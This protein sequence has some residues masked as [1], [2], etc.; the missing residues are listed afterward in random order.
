MDIYRHDTATSE[1]EFTNGDPAL[2]IP[3]TVL[4]AE[5]CNMIQREL[6]ALVTASGQELDG[7]NFAQVL[8][9]VQSMGFS[10]GDV[11]YTYQPQIPFGWLELNGGTIGRSG[12]G[13]SSLDNDRARPL[14][15]LLW[16]TYSNDVIPVT[17]G[18]GASAVADWDAGKPLKLFDDRNLFHRVASGLIP[19]GTW[20]DFAQQNVTG[21][22]GYIRDGREYADGVFEVEEFEGQTASSGSASGGRKISMDHSRQIKTDNEVRPVS[23]RI[24]ALIKL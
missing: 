12:S 6:I 15:L 20:Q 4:I 19:M 1:G 14:Y 8:A 9:A 22:F 23:R 18:R 21:Q 10:T 17:G 11:K 24:K 13:A 3:R 5:W 7:E 2:G 16:N